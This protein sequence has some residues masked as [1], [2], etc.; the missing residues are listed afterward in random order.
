M[1]K[2]VLDVLKKSGVPMTVPQI[3]EALKMGGKCPNKTTIYRQI[4]ALK[5]V[6][7]AQEVMLKNGIAF[8]EYKTDHHHHFFCIVCDT[9]QCFEDH[10]LER[11]IHT[12]EA[13]FKAKGLRVTHHEFNLF[14]MCA[15]CQK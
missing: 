13:N 11:L 5:D 2:M 10:D 8:Y 14:G 12:S 9:I 1:S 7:I 15:E 4:Q 6:G 3:L